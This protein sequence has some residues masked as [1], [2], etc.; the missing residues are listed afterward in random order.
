MSGIF[1]LL[2]TNS[3]GSGITVISDSSFGST[4]MSAEPF[5]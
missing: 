2:L 4:A 3:A 5:G 1:A